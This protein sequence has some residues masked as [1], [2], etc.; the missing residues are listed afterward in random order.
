MSQNELVMFAVMETKVK[1][2]RGGMRIG[3]V[4]MESANAKGTS[5]IV[6]VG[7]EEIVDDYR[8][9]EFYEMNLTRCQAPAVVPFGK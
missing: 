3:S 5:K 6:L 7:E 2:N 8:V 9:G 1:D 4:T